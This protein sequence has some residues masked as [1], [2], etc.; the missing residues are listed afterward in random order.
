MNGFGK[1]LGLS[2]AATVA[3]VLVLSGSVAATGSGYNQSYTQTSTVAVSA[4]GLTGVTSSY[5]G[6]PNLTASFTVAGVIDLSNSAY[7]YWVY[8]GGT[9]SSNASA[10]AEFTNNTTAGTWTAYSNSGSAFG[11]EAY[12]LSNGGSTLTF[13]L[14][15][16]SVGPSTGFAIDAYAYFLTGSAYDYSWLGTDYQPGAGGGG[17]GGSCGVGGCTVNGGGAAGFVFGG[18]LLFAVLGL[19]VVVIIIIVIVV[20]VTHGKKPPMG[21]PPPMPPGWM[22]PGQPGMAPPPPPPLSMPPPPPPT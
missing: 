6:G 8:F 2:A 18:F 17:G 13:Q 22:P 15:L 10:I 16:S 4:V 9:S 14:N 3:L 12:S 1:M 21:T 19:V 5:S 11:V 7:D 20:L